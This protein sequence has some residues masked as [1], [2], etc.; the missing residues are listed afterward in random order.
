M[1]DDNSNTLP[2]S[3]TARIGDA[4]HDERGR[5]VKGN[6]VAVGN[7]HARRAQQLRSALMKTIKPKWITAILK[8][9]LLLA[10]RKDDIGAA[11]TLLAYALGVPATS[12][13]LERLEQ[14]ELQMS[15]IEKEEAGKN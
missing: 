15:R 7:P 4:A 3:P 9:L 13:V 8:H 6:R 12:D 1:S 2:P 10:L 14:L 5:F 11:R